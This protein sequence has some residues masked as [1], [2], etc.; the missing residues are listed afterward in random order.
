MAA[1]K[2]THSR[3]I[4]RLAERAE[5]RGD[6]GPG[7][8]ALQFLAEDGQHIGVVVR[9]EDE[10]GLPAEGADGARAWVVWLLQMRGDEGRFMAV[11]ASSASELS[12]MQDVEVTDEIADTAVELARERHGEIEVAVQRASG[13]RLGSLVTDEAGLCVGCRT[14]EPATTDENVLL[15]PEG[16]VCAGCLSLTERLTW[17]EAVT[18]ALRKAGGTADQIKGME[19]QLA[20]LRAEIDGLGGGD[21]PSSGQPGG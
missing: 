13:L 19:R 5:A 8:E 11:M 4:R 6:A 17:A 16:P 20:S 2:L 15:A 7:N 1:A 12:G 21:A 3:A 14:N 10:D 9:M 18:A